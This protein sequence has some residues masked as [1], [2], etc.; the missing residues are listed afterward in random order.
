MLDAVSPSPL[1]PT[2][3][4]RGKPLLQSADASRWCIV[5]LETMPMKKGCIGSDLSIH[6]D[7]GA[8]APS[9]PVRGAEIAPQLDGD[10]ALDQTRAAAQHTKALSPGAA[11]RLNPKR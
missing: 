7:F 4:A 10:G 1:V 11:R 2:R 9:R 6:G 8:L 3:A 5:S